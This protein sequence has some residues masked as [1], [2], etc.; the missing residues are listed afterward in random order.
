MPPRG[1]SEKKRKALAQ[2]EASQ[3]A[4][5]ELADKGFAAAEKERKRRKDVVPILYG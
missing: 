4:W 3:C 1:S 5:K 2:S